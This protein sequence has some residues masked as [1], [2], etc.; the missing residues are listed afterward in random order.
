MF[1][2]LSDFLEKKQI[3]CFAPLPLEACLLTKPYLLEKEGIDAGSV[4]ML[5]IPY[6]TPFC[7]DPTR[8]L[9]AYAVPR[10]YHL[11]FK[12]LFGEILTLL[13]KHFPKH[14]FAA[15]A[16]HSPINEIDAA[17]KAGLGVIGKNGLLI[18]EKY[19]SYVFLGEIITDA[20]I[21]AVSK[22]IRTCLDCGACRRACSM[23][24][25][26]CPCLSSLTQ[27]KGELNEAEKA[28]LR[29][30]PLVWGCD[31]C[32]E[33]CPHTIQAKKNGTVYSPIPFFNEE[34]IGHLTG[35]VLEHLSDGEFS[36][37]AYA[38]RGRKTIERNLE[39]KEERKE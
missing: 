37:R 25:K 3:D 35:A 22:E 31:T 18:T 4:V 9:S 32:Q 33:V 7:E 15:F 39:L 2:F 21:P 19:S 14:R 1:S 17:A 6:Y 13:N 34:P 28:W 10:D 29:S 24:E 8:N 23:T 30:H 11:F 16:D 12:D 38:W 27:K 20:I 36:M 5:A 26:G